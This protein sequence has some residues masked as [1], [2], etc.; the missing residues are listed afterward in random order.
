M[1]RILI[2][3]IVGFAVSE[4]H[5]CSARKSASG[6]A[7]S[8]LFRLT[9]PL[10]A[11]QVRALYAQILALWAPQFL[12]LE[13]IPLPLEGWNYIDYRDDGVEKPAYNS[14]RFFGSARGACRITEF[15]LHGVEAMSDDNDYHTCT[16]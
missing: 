13:I 4:E 2:H 9:D 10:D 8:R 14:Y 6:A 7:A 16:P 12:Y 11:I 3:G 5:L 15:K 1:I